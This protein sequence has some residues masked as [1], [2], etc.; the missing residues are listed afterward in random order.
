MPNPIDI[1]D[2]H[3]AGEPT[4][5]VIAGGP[6]LGNGPLVE[7]LARLRQH[8]DTLRRTVI[9]EPRGSDVLVG[10]LLCPPHDP[11]ASA[12][13]IFSITWVIWGC[14]ATA[15]S[16]WSLVWHTSGASPSANIASKPP[17]ARLPPSS[18]L[19]AR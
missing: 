17:W 19:T 10:A 1:I 3:T 2:S 11:S 14:V 16:G 12:G 18:T 9:N 15:P 7:R 13:V 4:R 5:L 8:H 6:D